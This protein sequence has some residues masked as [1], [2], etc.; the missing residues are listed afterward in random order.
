MQA[1][2]HIFRYRKQAQTIISKVRTEL[3]CYISIYISNPR[4]SSAYWWMFSWVVKKFQHIHSIHGKWLLSKGCNKHLV[5]STETLPFEHLRCWG[6]IDFCRLYSMHETIICLATWKLQ[7]RLT[8]CPRCSIWITDK[9]R[10]YAIT[11]SA[12]FVRY[13]WASAYRSQ[14]RFLTNQPWP[15]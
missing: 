7:I 11:R 4:V 10:P 6:T 5:I 13:T 3:S 12:G 8:F 15:G 9:Q 14:P 2:I 1:F